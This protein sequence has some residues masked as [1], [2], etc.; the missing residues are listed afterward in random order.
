M[1]RQSGTALVMDGSITIL[2]TRSRRQ[3]DMLY[4]QMQHGI[5]FRKKKKI[6]L[7]TENIFSLSIYACYSQFFFF[8]LLTL[9]SVEFILEFHRSKKKKCWDDFIF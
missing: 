5:L 1:Q 3:G 8:F 2:Y 6:L 9:L 7:Q 4:M